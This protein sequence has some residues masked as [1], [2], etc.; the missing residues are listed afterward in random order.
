VSAEENPIPPEPEAEPSAPRR[1]QRTRTSTRSPLRYTGTSA[2]T[3]T[4]DGV[5]VA[6]YPNC[7]YLLDADHFQVRALVRDGYLV[8]A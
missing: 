2:M 7:T 5:S 4:V 6:L 1:R 3:V 8:R